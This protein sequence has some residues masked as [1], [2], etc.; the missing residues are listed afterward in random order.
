MEQRCYF[1]IRSSD[2]R[3]GIFL[4]KR[5]QNNETDLT[6]IYFKIEKVVGR[7]KSGDN[8]SYNRVLELKDFLNNNNSRTSE[9]FQEITKVPTPKPANDITD[10]KLR[11][12]ETIEGMKILVS[13]MKKSPKRSARKTFLLVQM[14]V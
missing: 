8:C 7:S 2:K 1:N 5:V 9:D 11:Q 6:F 12:K 4:S 14:T 13:N 10:E 3:Y